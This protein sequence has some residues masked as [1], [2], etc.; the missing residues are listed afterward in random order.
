MVVPIVPFIPC[1]PNIPLSPALPSTSYRDGGKSRFLN[2]ARAAF[3]DI[4]LPRPPDPGDIM[5]RFSRVWKARVAKGGRAA[6]FPADSAAVSAFEPEGRSL[7]IFKFQRT[8]CGTFG[9][10]RC[11]SKLPEPIRALRDVDAVAGNMER[12]V[13]GQNYSQQFTWAASTKEFPHR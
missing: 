11:S 4:A 10:I 2:V 13:S 3:L 5:M 1:C 9:L 7:L 6:P 12:L 8:S